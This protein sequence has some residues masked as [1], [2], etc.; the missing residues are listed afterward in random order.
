MDPEIAGREM[1][2]QRHGFE[3]DYHFACSSRQVIRRHLD[4]HIEGDAPV[5]D[6][7]FH[8]LVER[9]LALGAQKFRG[10]ALGLARLGQG[11]EL[12]GGGGAFEHGQ[13]LALG[14][15]VEHRPAPGE[16]LPDIAIALVHAEAQQRL[17][18]RP[19][20]FAGHVVAA[21]VGPPALGA[22]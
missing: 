13:R 22:L 21:Q 19:V 8:G 15:P 4:L 20:V 10:F 14:Q 1:G 16:R 18:G 7:G 17:G 5:L 12:V 6:E 9:R 2:D 3:V 11:R